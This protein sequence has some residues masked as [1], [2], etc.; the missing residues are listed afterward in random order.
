MFIK[1]TRAHSDGSFEDVC[2][3]LDFVF[4]IYRNGCGG[5]LL[6]FKSKVHKNG[7]ESVAYIN[8]AESMAEI[9]T[10]IKKEARE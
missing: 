2:L 8:V 9:Q 5:S 7:N 6:F 4:E 3:N 1:L 10:L